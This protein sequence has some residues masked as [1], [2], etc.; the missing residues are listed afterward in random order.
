MPLSAPSLRANDRAARRV[1]RNASAEPISGFGA[2]WRTATPMVER[3]SATRRGTSWH[4]AGGLA[5]ACFAMVR[6]A[7]EPGGRIMLTRR[8]FAQAA[9]ATVLAQPARAQ[10]AWPSRPI[11]I[12]VGYPAGGGVDLIARLLG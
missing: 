9:A 5:T 7:R 12:L 10:A 1:R 3:A 2:P 8:E 11:H 6:A 4:V